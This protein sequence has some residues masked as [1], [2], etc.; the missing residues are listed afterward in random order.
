MTD[1]KD[2]PKETTDKDDAGVK[3]GPGRPRSTPLKKYK[4][5]TRHCPFPVK[6]AVVEATD[7]KDAF[8][9]LAELNL[10]KVESMSKSGPELSRLIEAYRKDGD[11]QDL[12]ITEV[13]D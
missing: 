9:K 10:A 4:V 12:T 7:E 8:E 6:S 2:T 1:T 13:V 3:R 5:V 11:H